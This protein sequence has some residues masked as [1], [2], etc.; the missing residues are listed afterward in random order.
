MQARL[1][2]V[3]GHGMWLASPLG[4]NYVFNKSATICNYIIFVA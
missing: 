3:I 1:G 4:M 2:N